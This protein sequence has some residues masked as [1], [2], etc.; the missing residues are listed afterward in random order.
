MSAFHRAFTFRLGGVVSVSE[1]PGLPEPDLYRLLAQFSGEPLQPIR[2]LE[3]AGLRPKLQD[4][5]DLR[6]PARHSI[7]DHHRALLRHLHHETGR[8]RWVEWSTGKGKP[9][10][11]GYVLTGFGEAKLAEWGRQYGSAQAPR[12]GLGELARQRLIQRLVLLDAFGP[13]GV[14]AV[15][16]LEASGLRD[17][18]LGTPLAEEHEALLLDLQRNGWI[19]VSGC[20]YV[21]TP[22]GDVAAAS[23]RAALARKPQ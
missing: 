1:Q 13:S 19:V 12:V 2:A 3:A 22:A 6:D 18:G 11:E 14:T 16:A 17:E 15:C 7:S 23:R 9:P 20:G 10:T 8:I 21:R 4:P 5:D